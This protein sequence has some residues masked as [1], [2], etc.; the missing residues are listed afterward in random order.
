MTYLLTDLNMPGMDGLA[1]TRSIRAAEQER[2]GRLPIIAIT[3]TT[4]PA[5]LAA[6]R[7][8]GMDDVLPKPIELEDL[9][10]QLDRWLPA[11]SPMPPPIRCPRHRRGTWGPP[12]DPAYMTRSLGNLNQRQ[13]RDLVDL[14]TATA[15]AE[16][17]ACRHLR[18]ESDARTLMLAMHKLGSSAHGRRTPTRHPVRPIGRGRPDGPDGPGAIPVRRTRNAMPTWKRPRSGWPRR[19]RPPG[20]DRDAALA[21][22]SLPRSVLVVDDDAIARRQTSMLL[23]LMGVEKV[24]T[25]DSGEKALTEIERAGNDGI[26]LLI[27]DLRMPGMDGIEF[28]RRLANGGY[29][30]ALVISSGV[31]DRV[32]QD[33]ADL[34]RA[35]GLHLR[36]AVK[37]PLTR[38][39]MAGL[40][41]VS[42]EQLTRPVQAMGP[43]ILPSEILDGARRHEF[44]M[45]FQP[46]VDANTLRVV[47]LEALAR[48]QRDG[49][50]VRP[51]SSSA[52]PSAMA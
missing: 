19:R 42:R 21:P 30:G 22:E 23:T 39:V 16:L 6:C 27:T 31:D 33:A 9:R 20:E 14:F 13:M 2:G 34:I 36:G 12:L 47:G 37:K 1:L 29:P 26:D 52:R 4:Q 40:L 7:K 51:T 44:S 35:K 32:L 15:R 8:A 28:L 50:P 18:R 48:W 5:A 43:D 11:R 41:T 38:E 46:K 24:L 45:H 3:G 10:R 25:V 49:R 17:H